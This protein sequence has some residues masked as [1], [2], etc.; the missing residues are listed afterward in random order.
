M[1]LRSSGPCSG[2]LTL[3]FPSA[4]EEIDNTVSFLREFDSGLNCVVLVEQ[5]LGGE[6]KESGWLDSPVTQAVAEWNGTV[7]QFDLTNPRAVA[8]HRLDG[9]GSWASSGCSADDLRD[10]ITTAPDRASLF[11]GVG[12]VGEQAALRESWVRMQPG[13][14]V[15]F[16]RAFARDD[17]SWELLA[18]ETTWASDYALEI[19]EY[20]LWTSRTTADPTVA[21]YDVE[22]INNRP[23][24]ERNHSA[25]LAVLA[26]DVIFEDTGVRLNNFLED[27]AAMLIEIPVI[28][29]D[30]PNTI[31]G[32]HFIHYTGSA[33]AGGS[34][35]RWWC[36][37]SVVG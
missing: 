34:G 28:T 16:H 25:G 21:P 18:G 30:D 6:W 24:E 19:P 1:L 12:C 31:V 8:A 3:Y 10:L 5:T 37:V 33:E 7:V 11:T 2:W 15:G 17:G 27:P 29:P 23:V 13:P 26:A 36:V 9:V 4:V 32:W 35:R 20:E 14:P 22:S